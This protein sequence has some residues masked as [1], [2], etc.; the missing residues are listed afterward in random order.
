MEYWLANGNAMLNT[1]N[2]FRDLFYTLG[3]YK[4]IRDP[5]TSLNLEILDEHRAETSSVQLTPLCSAPR[6]CVFGPDDGSTVDK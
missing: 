3:W 5:V 2:D 4:V 6:G 1:D